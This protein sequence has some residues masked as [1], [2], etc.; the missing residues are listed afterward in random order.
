MIRTLF[1]PPL[2]F[3]TLPT[4]STPQT[5]LLFGR[6]A[7]QSPLTGFLAQ[8]SVEVSSTETTPIVLLSR[9]GSI[10]STY[11]SGDDRA[12]ILA[13]SEAGQRSVLGML[14]SATVSQQRE[15]SANP[16]GIFHS[17]G[18]NSETSFLRFRSGTVK[19]IARRQDKR[20]SSRDLGV[21]PDSHPEREKVLSQHRDLRNFLKSERIKLFEE[22]ELLGQNCLEPKII[23]RGFMK[24]KKSICCLK[25]NLSWTSKT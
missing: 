18:E 2:T 8:S 1:D 23:R 24:N 21:V 15:T 20:K 17:D 25:R 22:A 12:T 3:P 10:G 11:N 13:A 4:T 16:F 9:K 6:L 7:E 14:A 5:G 19:T